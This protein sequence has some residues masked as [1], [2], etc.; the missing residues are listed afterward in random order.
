MSA[1]E[2]SGEQEARRWRLP[3]INPVWFILAAL[4]TAI[5]IENANFLAPIGYMNFLKR[6]APLAILAAGQVYVI[7]SGG[8][9]L[10]VGSLIT[11]TVVGSSMLTRHL[12][13]LRADEHSRRPAREHPAGG[14]DRDGRRRHSPDAADAPDIVR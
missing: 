11:L 9:D 12:P 8:F 10:S 1:V 7:V 6:A 5:A 14:A 2:R 3:A 4:I 13:R